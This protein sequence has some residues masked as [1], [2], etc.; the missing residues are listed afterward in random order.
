M[1][2]SFYDDIVFLVVNRSVNENTLSPE[3]E[4]KVLLSAKTAESSHFCRF[5]LF[6]M[7]E[8]KTTS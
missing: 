3:V 1:R 5:A 4:V 7:Y 8:Y 6:L 2:F